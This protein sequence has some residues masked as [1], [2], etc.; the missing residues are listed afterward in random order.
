MFGNR[1]NGMV[2]LQELANRDIPESLYL[3]HQG[4]WKTNAWNKPSFVHG[5]LTDRRIGLAGFGS[6][7]RLYT[8]LVAPLRCTTT[9]YAPYLAD[10]PHLQNLLRSAKSSPSAFLRRQQPK[11]LSAEKPSIL[12][13]GN[14]CSR[15]SHAWPWSSR[16]R[17]GKALRQERFLRRSTCSHRKSLPT[18][19]R[20]RRHPNVVATPHIAGAQSSAI[21]VAYRCK[22]TIAVTTGSEPRFRATLR[23]DVCHQGTLDQK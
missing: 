15:S 1:F 17:C 3:V 19:A 13:H 5:D 14:L 8:E 23:D 10:V 2:D 20:F 9:S 11:K 21:D 18:D 16:T 4:E 7:N 6:V 12:C 22:D